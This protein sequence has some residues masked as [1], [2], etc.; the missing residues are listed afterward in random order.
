[1]N[2]NP[3]QAG[4]ERRMQRRE[5][6][7]CGAS[8]AAF[9]A[10]KRRALRCALLAFTLLELLVV[11]SILGI[12]AA[13]SVPAIKSL[14]KSNAQVG[15]AQEML[16]DVQQARRLAIS[17]HTTVYMVFVPENFWLP[18]G[19][20]SW[21]NA[22]TYDQRA[23]VTNL[24]DKQFR[25]YV[26]CSLRSVGDQPGRGVPEYIGEWR[27]LPEGAFIATNKFDCNDFY[28]AYPNNFYPIYDYPANATYKIY[29]FYTNSFPFPTE[30]NLPPANLSPNSWPMLPYIAFNYMGQLTV[31]GNTIARRDEYIP[32][33]QG[34]VSYARDVNHA[35]QLGAPDATEQP[36][37]NSTNSMFN[38][39]HIDRLTGRAELL[40]E[41]VQ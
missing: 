32:L 13:L 40:Q 21:F 5:A 33:A 11:I 17:R 9:A 23:A 29:S 14:G 2:G 8:G 27:S 10:P 36:P 18:G 38:I 7:S 3:R 28:P 24:L 41:Q 12:L 1:M 31:D 16:A 19:G 30:T 39:V 34:S 25:G 4:R 26:Y 6:V 22:L 35:L 15:A 37:G 20:L